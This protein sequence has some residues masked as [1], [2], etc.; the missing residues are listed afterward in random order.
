MVTTKVS[1]PCYHETESVD[2]CELFLLNLFEAYSKLYKT[3]NLWD[4]AKLYSSLHF[5][6][7]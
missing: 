4:V 1:Q 2:V 3:N 5:S 7:T 6:H